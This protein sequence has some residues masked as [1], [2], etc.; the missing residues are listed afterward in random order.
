MNESIL[1]RTL[2]NYR[3][4]RRPDFH[5]PATKDS[6]TSIENGDR[7]EKVSPSA[8][9][10]CRSMA[11]FK[12]VH[13][14]RISLASILLPTFRGNDVQVQL[15]SFFVLLPPQSSLGNFFYFGIGLLEIIFAGKEEEGE[16]G[17]KQDKEN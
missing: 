8:D 9:N 5:Q 15:Y 13:P 4:V 1:L 11:C 12:R 17:R 14:V 10:V 3:K 7:L 6:K 16:R 2:R